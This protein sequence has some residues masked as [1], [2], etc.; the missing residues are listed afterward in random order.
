MRHLATGTVDPP[1]RRSGEGR[2]MLNFTGPDL[3]CACR[4]IEGRG[5]WTTRRLTQ[6][7]AAA[8]RLR[9]FGGR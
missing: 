5:I 9:R 3:E 7:T 6:L 1:K 2:V 4:G 8:L